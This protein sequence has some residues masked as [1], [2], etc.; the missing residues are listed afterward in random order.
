MSHQN[1]SPSRTA[2][3]LEIGSAL[4]CSPLERIAAGASALMALI[5]K[6]FGIADPKGAHRQADLEQAFDSFKYVRRELRSRAPTPV[7]DVSPAIVDW[8]QNAVPAIVGPDMSRSR[9]LD[10]NARC[11]KVPTMI[12]V[13]FWETRLLT[14]PVSRLQRTGNSAG[15]QRSERVLRLHDRPGGLSHSYFLR[16]TWGRT[17]FSRSEEHTSELQSRR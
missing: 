8:P 10:A 4:T 17:A 3:E 14:N 11:V 6:A 2:S 9:Q 16:M 5:W 15:A 1:R 7:V 12:L 13:T